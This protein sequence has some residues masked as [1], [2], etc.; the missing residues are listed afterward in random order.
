MMLLAPT[1]QS[2]VLLR[3]LH[4]MGKSVSLQCV[5][6]SVFLLGGAL[7]ANLG[8]PILVVMMLVAKTH[9]LIKAIDHQF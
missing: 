2:S 4:E 8:F 3:Y 6:S 9:H 7:D 1:K 5:C